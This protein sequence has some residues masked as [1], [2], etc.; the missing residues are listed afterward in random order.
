MIASTISM[1]HLPSHHYYIYCLITSSIIS[2]LHL[3]SH[4]Y[5]IYCL[6]IITISPRSPSTQTAAG[7][8]RTL[9]VHSYRTPSRCCWRWQP[10]PWR[11]CL[12]SQRRRAGLLHC[13]TTYGRHTLE[14]LINVLVCLFISKKIT[15]YTD[16][17][18]HYTFIKFMRLYWAD[19]ICAI[20]HLIPLYTTI[21]LLGTQ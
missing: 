20:C 3:P 10:L 14:C 6:N 5:F 17:I 16:P 7:P 9:L 13:S 12:H 19:E 8:R 4:H 21:L 1:L 18:W 2:I 11:P 15:L